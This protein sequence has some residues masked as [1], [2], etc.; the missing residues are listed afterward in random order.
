LGT[1]H[2]VSVPT[3]PDS[4]ID[5]TELERCAR[6]VLEGGRKIAAFVATLG[7]T[8][9]F[10]LDD[11]EG[12]VALRD[13]LAEEYHQS[14]RPHIHADA[15]IGWAWS[16]FKDYEFEANP[17]GFRPRTVRALAGACRR[18]R[19]LHLADSIGVDFHKTGF[20]PYIS[21]LFLLKNG[22]DFNLISRAPE[23]MPY[24]YHFGEHRPGIFTLE[25]S[26]AGTGVLAARA[27]LR[28]LGKQGW[29][30]AVGHL[31][32][33]TEL[34]REHL[35]GHE[36]TTVLNRDN[37]GTVTLFRVYPEGVDTFAI[38]QHEFE[39]VAFR[40]LLQRHNDYNRRIFEYVQEEALSGRGVM[41]SLTDCYR[42]TAYGAPIVALKSFILSPFVGEE[43]I[44]IVVDKILEARKHID[45]MTGP[46]PA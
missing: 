35:E 4:S 2:L 40:D 1:K 18:L 29:R 15:V 34:L 43:H 9:T 27:N 28:L 17:L 7:S 5:I 37:F 46:K 24:L 20:A 3:R 11:L 12:M 38:K 33:M 8:D 44:Q 14:Y 26:R 19:H 10:G 30:A 36:A 21:S 16:V 45:G 41:I 22:A 31:V 42:H 23:H 6:E 25:T 32:E 39:D 13:A